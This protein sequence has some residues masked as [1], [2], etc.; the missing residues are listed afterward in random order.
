VNSQEAE[1]ILYG[2]ELALAAEKESRIKKLLYG[3]QG[4]GAKNV[5]ITDGDNGSFAEDENNQFY[6][7]GVEKVNVV[8]K[9][10][11]GDAYTAGF[12]AAVLSGKPIGEAMRWGT[13]NS[14]SVVQKIGA[15]EGLLKKVELEEELNSSKVN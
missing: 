10:G 15:E 9:T 12:L 4:L 8:E 11:A 2:K 1:E 7:L 14:A 6:G 13:L 3:L 5:V